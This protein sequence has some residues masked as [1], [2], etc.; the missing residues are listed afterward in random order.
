MRA[1]HLPYTQCASAARMGEWVWHS[2]GDAKALPEVH[3]AWDA[4]VDVRVSRTLH[5]DGEHFMR[6]AGLGQGARV[7]LVAGFECEH[8]RSRSFPWRRNVAL[9][10]SFE[11]SLEVTAHASRL[12]CSV[13]FMV[14]AILLSPGKNPSPVAA[15]VAGAW[16]WLDRTSFALQGSGGRF[17]MEW[18]AFRSSGLPPNATW[19]LD[20]PSQDWTAPALGTLRLLLNSDNGVARKVMGLPEHDARRKLVIQAARLDVAKQLVIA[21]LSSDDFFTD[22]D[23]FVEGSVGFSVRLLMTIAFPHDQ[24]KTLRERLIHQA[25]EFHAQLQDGLGAF[26]VELGD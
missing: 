7:R 4:S 9:P 16:L 14:G 19:F 13:D 20:W 8:A 15:N 11:G 23:H 25:G 1:V 22:I 5:F 10:S 6:G 21:A 2:E 24:P 12:A 17:P 26:D 18:V 3:P